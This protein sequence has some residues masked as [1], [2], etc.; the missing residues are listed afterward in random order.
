MFA[1]QPCLRAWGLLTLGFLCL[2]T[3]VPASAQSGPEHQQAGASVA[4]L[5]FDSGKKWATDASLRS[6]MAAIR[7]AFEADRIAIRDGRETDTQYEDLAGR[8]QSQVSSIMANCR[9]PPVAD[10][11][12]HY[13]IADLLQGVNLMLGKDPSHPPSD[14]STLVH[15]ALVAYGKYFD[16]PGWVPES[17]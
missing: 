16:D 13:V 2:A 4:N 1:L 15:G 6:G 7:A 8:I 17:P 14:G 12:L 9:L 3:A 10:A 5:Q 11:N